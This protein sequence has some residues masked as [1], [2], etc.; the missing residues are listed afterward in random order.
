MSLVHAAACHRHPAHLTWTASS[1]VLTLPA[2]VQSWHHL[3]LAAA[4]CALSIPHWLRWPPVVAVLQQGL[5]LAGAALLLHGHLLRCPCLHVAL[6]LN[7]DLCQMA[8]AVDKP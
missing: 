2:A 3:G 7:D 6:L 1:T 5:L 8:H 4:R